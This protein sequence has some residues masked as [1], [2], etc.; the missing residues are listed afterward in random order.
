MSGHNLAKN[1]SQGKNI[2]TF[3]RKKNSNNID[4]DQHPFAAIQAKYI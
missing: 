2:N 4:L 3:R 1:G